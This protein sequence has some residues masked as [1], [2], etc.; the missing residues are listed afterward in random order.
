VRDR[1]EIVRRFDEW[2]AVSGRL[3]WLY[4]EK[5]PDSEIDFYKTRNIPKEQAGREVLNYLRRHPGTDAL[6]IAKAL[7]ISPGLSF[8]ICDELLSQ[9]YLQ[10]SLNYF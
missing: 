8:Q 10:S 1:P 6:D 4:F 5:T 3:D 2:A 9:G 7:K